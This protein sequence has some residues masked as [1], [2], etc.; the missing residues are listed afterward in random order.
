MKYSLEF[1]LECVN[2]YKNGEYV[3]MPNNCKCDRRE[4]VRKIREWNDLYDK[5]RYQ[6]VEVK[7]H[8]I[9]RKTVKEREEKSRI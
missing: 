4:F 7:L 9:Q 6:G 5:M 8:Y 1:K 2:K 3:H